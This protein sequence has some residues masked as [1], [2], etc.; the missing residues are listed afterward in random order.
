M[1]DAPRETRDHLFISYAWE[2]G[3]LAEWLT[4][5]L[6][7]E[8][9]RVWCDR[10][11]LLGGESWPRDIDL[12]IKTKTFRMLHLVSAHSVDKANPSKERQLA[13]A[14]ERERGGE[15]FIPLNIDGRK[16]TD[17]N[18]QISDIVWIP[19]EDWGAGLHQLIKKLDSISAPRPLHE[20]GNRVVCEALPP[21]KVIRNEPETLVTNWFPFLAVPPVIKSFSATLADADKVWEALR[22]AWPHRKSE[23]RFLSLVD[24]PKDVDESKLLRS[25]GGSSWADL[26]KISGVRSE[27]LV[28]EL[29]NKTLICRC[30]TLGLKQVG[31]T[32]VLYF[33][34]GLVDDEKVTF[35][36]PRETST[37][38]TH[39][40]LS[41]RRRSGTSFFRHHLA[42]ELRAR[43]GAG[44]M[45]VAQLNLRIH[46][47]D[48]SGA[49]ST[50]KRSFR[51]S[52]AVRRG[53][54]NWQ[55]LMRQL[56]IMEFLSGGTDR[57]SLDS[58]PAIPFSLSRTAL[59]YEAAARIDET[60]PLMT[61]EDPGLELANLPEDHFDGHADDEDDG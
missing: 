9:Y 52:A 45:L 35:Y 11:K 16:P 20:N 31:S 15:F 47:T 1:D 18:W 27:N 59:S 29:L 25:A 60:S 2:D 55:Q 17:L 41:G 43:R 8:G 46:V 57:I 26:D 28:L 50:P 4:L 12:A 5:R 10:F 22:D 44:K 14:L 51:R 23:N 3:A 19:F 36:P 38:R 33:P 61:R 30:R 7:G 34:P 6:T 21:P 40:R 13:L 58:D 54:F 49:L 24:P 37:R 48:E 32:D 56:G 39:I 53:W 42:F